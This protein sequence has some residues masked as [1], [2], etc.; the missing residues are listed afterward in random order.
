MCAGTIDGSA[1]QPSLYRKATAMGIV[2]SIAKN[3]PGG[4]QLYRSLRRRYEHYRL[5]KKTPAEVFTEIFSKNGWSGDE[6]VSGLGSSMSQTRVLIDTLP[7]L[8]KERGIH[9]I[10]DAPCGDFHWMKHVDLASFDYLGGDI[11]ESVVARNK[12]HEKPGIRF[13][14]IDLIKDT[15]PKVDVVFCRDCLVHFSYGDLKAA[16]ANICKSD[17]TYLLTTTFPERNRNN[18]IATGEWR[19]LNLAIAPFNFPPPLVLINENCTEAEGK[20]TDKSMGLW[21]IADIKKCL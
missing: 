10:L 2:F 14:H 11:V 15:L 17:S 12:Q 8:F 16:L 4:P 5:K 20:F 21:K 13:Q 9:T 1:N 19:P 7:A 3:I 6:S 18:D